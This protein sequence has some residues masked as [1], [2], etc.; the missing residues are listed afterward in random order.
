MPEYYTFVAKTVAQAAEA[1]DHAHRHGIVHRD[2]KPSNILFTKHGEPRLSDFGLAVDSGEAS[3]TVTGAIVGTPRYMSPEQ[4]ILHHV[5]V[6]AR[7]DVY[8]LGVTLYELITLL[9]PFAAPTRERLL[10]QIATQDARSPRK[11]NPY[12]PRDLQTI[13]MKA[14]EKNPERRYQSAQLMADDLRRFLAGEPILAEPPSVTEL[15]WRAMRRHRT[16]FAA[17]AAAVVF[18]V[19]G[20]SVTWHT[21]KKRTRERA[22]QQVAELTTAAHQAEGLDDPAK[23]AELYKSILT[24]DPDNALV[25]ADLSRIQADVRAQKRA[26]EMERK[27]ELAEKDVQ[28]ALPRSQSYRQLR[29]KIKDAQ[30]EF[31]QLSRD[32][33]GILPV[34]NTDMNPVA[35]EY[36]QGTLLTTIEQAR[37][38]SEVAFADAVRL[39]HEALTH[40]PACA[41]ARRALTELYCWALE[42]AEKRRDWQ[43][44]KLYEQMAKLYDDG[45]YAQTLAGEGTVSLTT[46]P[47]GATC[48]L[49]VRTMEDGRF[50]WK[51]D[52]NLGNTPLTN[53]QLP[54]GS[55]LITIRSEGYAP[56]SCPVYLPRCGTE[57]LKVSL[58]RPDQ[59]PQNM[60]FVPGG[61]C[62][63]GGDPDALNPM[64]TG[65]TFVPA[66]FIGK[67]EV[68]RQEYQ[69]F[70][71]TIAQYDPERAKTLVPTAGEDGE[72][73]WQKTENGRYAYTGS[74]NLPVNG[75]SAHDAEQYCQ[76]MAETT[77]KPFRLPTGIEWEKAARG[78]DGRLF[79]WGN[80][81]LRGLSNAKFLQQ[82]PEKRAVCECGVYLQDASPYGVLDMAGNVSEVCADPFDT[83]G[84]WALRGG[85]WYAG[86]ELCRLATRS[87]ISPKTK[88]PA[89]GIRL[90]CDVPK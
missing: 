37:H 58:L 8:S 4:L 38:E 17:A 65:R 82:D 83:S 86:I 52:K 21:Q 48:T 54:Q 56:V 15:G 20:V 31:D 59:I 87:R 36:R 9:V 42:D 68:T 1:L 32:L 79:P 47:A 74:P 69:R 40:D 49:H 71:D 72:R 7:T 77:G 5:Q 11:T 45:Q 90:A 46:M 61:C 89:I 18:L 80:R 24:L 64:P 51:Q 60:V 88:H 6:D 35:M 43:N 33:N 26:E 44:A 66:F 14:M 81:P 50:A 55:Y 12:L 76:W 41:S 53:L 57:S 19:A 28:R 13:A 30:A 67:T 78:A 23:A 2:V 10:V 27:R 22:E 34:V 62:L 25:A 29:L 75:V 39:L 63:T 3:L 85:R 16:L 70:L 73:V 84:N